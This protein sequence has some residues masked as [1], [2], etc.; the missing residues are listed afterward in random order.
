MGFR[1]TLKVFGE[2]SSKIL[3]LIHK[4]FQSGKN[5]QKI[6]L[7]TPSDATMPDLRDPTLMN[8]RVALKL[9]AYKSIWKLRQMNLTY[10]DSI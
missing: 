10:E 6:D 4:K 1:Y 7:L 9:F 2:D 5:L 3:I 8:R